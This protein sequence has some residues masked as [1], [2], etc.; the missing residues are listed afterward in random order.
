MPRRV[1]PL[2]PSRM[3]ERAGPAMMHVVAP[4][5]PLLLPLFYLTVAFPLPSFSFI[6]CLVMEYDDAM[7]TEE[8]AP[9]AAR[10]TGG[11]AVAWGAGMGGAE[12]LHDPSGCSRESTMTV[13]DACEQQP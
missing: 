7:A 6:V 13:S 8:Q 1:F 2:E 12:A 9:V 11:G 5:P 4:L 3:I 10:A